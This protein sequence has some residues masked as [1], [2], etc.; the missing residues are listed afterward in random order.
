MAKMILAQVS[1]TEMEA[2]LQEMRKK[3]RKLLGSDKLRAIKIG[4][5]KALHVLR[6]RAYL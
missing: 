6:P 3:P 4:V 2:G 1:W 5:L